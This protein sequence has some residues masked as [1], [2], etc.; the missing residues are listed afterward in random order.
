MTLGLEG[1]RG[2]GLGLTA[3]GVYALGPLPKAERMGSSVSGL[4][5]RKLLKEAP[6]YL[7]VQNPPCI[8][9]PIILN[10]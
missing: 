7:Q 2:L 4:K 1:C 9:T 3:A 10:L 8:L 5:V 6:Y